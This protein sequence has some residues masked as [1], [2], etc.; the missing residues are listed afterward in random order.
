M[1]RIV[2][3]PEERRNELIDIAETLFIEKGYKDTTVE[4]IITKAQVAKGTFYYYFKSKNN[5][6]DAVI[7]QYIKEIGTFMKDIVL[8]DGVNAIEK[9]RNILKFFAEYNNN[10]NKFFGYIHEEKNAHLH[11]KIEKKFVPV[12]VHSFADII[13]EGVQ[14]GVFNTLYPTEAALAFLSLAVQFGNTHQKYINMDDNKRVEAALDIIER[15]LGAKPGILLNVVKEIKNEDM[16][17][18]EEKEVG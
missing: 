18:H 6:L 14:Q 13:E 8:T 15:I 5:I 3:N 17:Q 7:D 2:K 11:V 12:F 10:H 4:D 16:V 1:T 9:I